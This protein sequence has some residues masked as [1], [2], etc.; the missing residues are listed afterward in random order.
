MSSLAKQTPLPAVTEPAQ[1]SKAVLAGTALIGEQSLATLQRYR[2]RYSVVCSLSTA[3]ID[4]LRGLSETTGRT[5]DDFI[6]D[7]LALPG[8]IPEDRKE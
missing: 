2:D 5:F 1:I 7:I 3:Q 6:D 8:S 4:S